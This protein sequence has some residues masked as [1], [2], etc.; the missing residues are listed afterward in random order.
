[1]K[2]AIQGCGHGNLQA[3]YRALAEQ[4]ARSGAKADLLLVCGDFQAIRHRADLETLACPPKYRHMGDF[5]DYWSDR[6]R[7]P[8]LTL[9][10]GG[11]HEAS[12]HLW[13]LYYGGWVA[14]NM[15]YLGHSGVVRVGGLRI[16]GVSGIYNARHYHLGYFERPPYTDSTLRSVYHT[17]EYEIAK[18]SLLSPG[19]SSSAGAPL[20][21]FMSHEWPHRIYDHGNVQQL[22]RAKPYFASDIEARG[23]GAP[24]LA[25][26]LQRLQPRHWFA[27][28]MHVRFEATVHH[29]AASEA[30][31]GDEGSAAPGIT[32]FLALD[33]CLPHRKHLEIIDIPSDPL[34][35]DGRPPELEYDDDWLAIV[36]AMHPFL[37][38]RSSPTHLPPQEQIDLAPHRQ[39][40]QELRAR[41]S[42]RL[43]IPT[44]YSAK[45]ADRPGR[46]TTLRQTAEFCEML[47]I[48]NDCWVEDAQAA[49]SGAVNEDEIV[50]D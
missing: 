50:F 38:L 39:F 4:E 14:P 25:T 12:Q 44:N 29:P 33:K 17:R 3:I 6:R 34:P 21:V 40:V 49:D 7:A 27:A 18:L 48:S 32:Q 1:M 20:D 2:V 41:R 9:F 5:A 42:G 36:R 45:P 8:L 28:H 26:L 15:Y 31:A 16:G 13:Q 10:I 37:N 22:L 46:R 35:D 19:S 47:G 43:R 30:T 23:I 24:P 11:N